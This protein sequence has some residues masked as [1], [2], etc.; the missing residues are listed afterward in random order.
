MGEASSS[1]SS[2]SNACEQDAQRLPIRA[3]A[4]ERIQ[5][6]LSAEEKIRSGSDHV[7][8]TEAPFAFQNVTWRERVAQWCY[9]VIDHLELPREV[10]Y[11][12]MN[13]LDRYIASSHTPFSQ[14]KDVYEATAITSLFLA[15]RISGSMDIKVPDLL[16]MS[17]SS[18]QTKDIHSTGSSILETLTFSQQILTPTAFV[19]ALM[20]FLTSSLSTRNSMSLF[21]LS[22]YLVEIAVCDQQFC[23]VRPQELAFAALFIAMSEQSEAVDRKT[24]SLFVHLVQQETGMSPTSPQVASICA[25]LRDLYNQTQDSS[26]SGAPHVVLDDEEDEEEAPPRKRSS[27]T[28]INQLRDDDIVDLRPMTHSQSGSLKRARSF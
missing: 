18:A 10:V 3:T 28:E 6:M 11:L 5:K 25:R 2:S 15:I 9:D 24:L 22:S 8:L 23:R 14:D 21:E 4:I 20:S 17:R 16:C 27:E 12:A 1:S 26:R 7:A 19:K 13:I